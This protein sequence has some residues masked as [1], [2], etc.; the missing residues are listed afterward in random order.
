LTA[1]PVRKTYWVYTNQSLFELVVGNEDRDVWKIFLEKGK[2]EV[3]LKYAK[4]VSTM[5]DVSASTLSPRLQTPEQRDL[6]LAAQA[7]AFFSEQRYFDAA[8]CYAQCSV[9]F[10][11]VALKFLDVGER[12][13]FRSYLV[14]RLERTRKSASIFNSFPTNVK[15][16]V[17]ARI[18]LK[19]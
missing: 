2:F 11:E 18:S 4:V 14:S 5:S 12:D 9:T 6:I 8:Q 7:Q 17:L 10:E 16:K 3:A 13:A 19:E 1:D 15:L